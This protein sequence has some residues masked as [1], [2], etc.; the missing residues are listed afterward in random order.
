MRMTQ[1]DVSG[2]VSLSSPRF[3][4]P[5]HLHHLTRAPSCLAASGIDCVVHPV[6]HVVADLPGVFV[7][8]DWH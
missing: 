7:V 1:L 2:L 3:H 6:Y 8:V 4:H 5:L